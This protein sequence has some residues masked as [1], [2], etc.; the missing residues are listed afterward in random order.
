[1]SSSAK[2]SGVGKRRPSAMRTPIETR[3][4]APTATGAIT[5]ARTR[6]RDASIAGRP[7]RSSSIATQDLPHLPPHSRK[8][9]MLLVEA[10]VLSR[11]R[12]LS[13]HRLPNGLAASKLLERGGIEIRDTLQ[14]K[15]AP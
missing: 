9:R 1:M 5:A 10:D 15:L 2:K 8:L 14:L 3:I 11:P 4:S 13:H 12:D 7:R 6:R